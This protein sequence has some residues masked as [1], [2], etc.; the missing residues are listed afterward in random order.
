MCFG[1]GPIVVG[2]ADRHVPRQR[3]LELD[4]DR[5]RLGRRERLDPLE[6]F[7]PD[8]VVLFLAGFL[9]GEQ[10]VV[11]GDRLPV[12]PLQ[13]RPQLEG[14][15]LAVL[16]DVPLGGGVRSYSSVLASCSMKPPPN[17]R[18]ATWT[19][20]SLYAAL[21]GYG[22][23]FFGSGPMLATTNVPP[24]TVG[25]PASGPASRPRACRVPQQSPPSA[26]R[27][28]GA[29]RHRRTAPPSAWAPHQRVMADRTPRP[30]AGSRVRAPG[31]GACPVAGS[32]RPPPENR[33]SSEPLTRAL[34]PGG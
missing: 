14:E 8:V 4:D 27:R 25:R 5:L 17:I 9:V 24:G 33:G 29:S 12:A 20:P 6:V 10:V 21:S 11:D 16:R 34:A 30:E 19:Q 15:R 7:Q 2:H 3:L 23:T 18:P 31:S 32:F 13:V 1:T 26:S 28:Q 22:C